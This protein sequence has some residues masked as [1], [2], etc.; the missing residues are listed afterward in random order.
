MK[1]YLFSLILISSLVQAQGVTYNLGRTALDSEIQQWDIAI[2]P[3]D[4]KE[5]PQGRGSV[6]DGEKLYATK[7]LA[8]HGVDGVGA[9]APRLVGRNTMGSNWPFA[10]SVWSYINRAMP[11]Y[12]EGS[13]SSDEVYALTAFLLHKNGIIPES[14]ELT[15]AN[16]LDVEMPNKNGYVPPPIDQWEPGMQ[17]LFKIIGPE[18]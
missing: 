3:G 15:Q 2:N 16:L 1:Y 13:L 10:S 18:Y 14:A 8:C 9:S 11:L 5:L 4:G 6:V 7:C 12:L 17:R